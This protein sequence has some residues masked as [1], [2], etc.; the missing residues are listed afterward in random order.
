MFRSLRNASFVAGGLLLACTSDNGVTDPAGSISITLGS[1]TIVIANGGS[2]TVNVSIVRNDG[3]TGA[4]GLAVEGTPEGVTGTLSPSS[5]AGSATTSVLTLSAAASASPGSHTLTVRATGEGVA[6]G[7]ASLTAQI[8]AMPAYTLA[9]D[10]VSLNVEP[11]NSRDAALT[12]TR[13]NFGGAITLTVG[14][15]PAGVTASVSPSPTTGGSATLAVTVDGGVAPGNHALT[16]TGQAEGL[17]DRTLPLTLNIVA[18]DEVQIETPGDQAP[19]IGQPFTLE[20]TASGPGTLTFA[21]IGQPL[22]DGLALAAA[23]GVISGM[24][25]AAAL[26]TGS[27]AGVWDGIVIEVSNGTASTQTEPFP[28]SVVGGELPTPYAYIPFD[29]D[30][31]DVFGRVGAAMGTVTPGVAGAIGNAVFIGGTNSRIRYPPSIASHLNGKAGFSYAT[32]IRTTSTTSMFFGLADASLGW[33]RAYAEL[34]EGRIRFGGRSQQRQLESFQ[35]ATGSIAIDDG[36]FHTFVGTMDL[37][38]DQ[39]SIYIDGMLDTTGGAAFNLNAF[40]TFAPADENLIGHYTDN[41]DTSTAPNV[42]HDEVAFW[43]MVLDANQVATVRWLVLSGT[44]LRD[45]IGF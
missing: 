7:T 4:V 39:I 10:P 25:T 36:E 40:E 34:A 12:I 8:A 14:G 11:G 44:R 24:P 9:L 33:N 22:P 32:T 38:A 42:D 3:F 2:N 21:S 28:I 18:T 29:A 15:A 30:I 43:D 41:A 27:P 20:L 17:S 45:W 5:L 37:P 16:V 13:T 26:L 6:D 19:V 31:N 1:S 35:S 23:T